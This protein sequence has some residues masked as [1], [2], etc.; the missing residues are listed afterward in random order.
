MNNLISLIDKQVKAKGHNEYNKIDQDK[1]KSFFFNEDYLL[2]DKLYQV[3]KLTLP[4]QRP[5]LLY[6]GC[7]SD[8]FTPL[9][10]LERL[11]PELKETNMIFIDTSYTLGLIKTQLDEVGISFSEPSKNNISF[12]WN[13]IF[14][15][16]KFEEKN[17]FTI[18]L[19]EFNVYFEKAFRIMKEQDL[20]YEDKIIQKLTKNGILISDSGFQQ[21]IK[22]IPISPELSSY[23]E[24]VLGVKS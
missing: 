14:I 3:P 23:G 2:L 12:Y 7:G 22:Q 4:Q 1:L 16:L 20:N 5:T 9:I 17:I 19:P 11:F 6:P 15:K 8:I 10:Y 24:M 18:F 21:K 13:N